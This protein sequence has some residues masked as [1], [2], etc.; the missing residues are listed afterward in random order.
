MKI[1]FVDIKYCLMHCFS[2][3]FQTK[4]KRVGRL[5]IK[6]KLNISTSESCTGGLISSRLTDISGSS[7]YIMQN[8]VTYANSAKIEL[9]GV[10]TKTIEQFGV[11][12]EEVAK[13][14]AE[15][16]IKKYGCDIALSTTGI[17][18]PTGSTKNKPVGLVCICVADKNIQKTYSYKANPHLT[19]RLMKY[20]FSD[21]ALEY[22]IKFLEKCYEK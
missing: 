19:R 7:A 20:E 3:I 4:E 17:A 8:F 13:E 16:L 10:R 5:L 22:L 11:V 15:G 21:K 12:S 18:G 6:N 2:F 9:L 1:A 14:M